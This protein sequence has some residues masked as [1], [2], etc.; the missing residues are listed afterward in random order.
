[1]KKIMLM[2]ILAIATLTVLTKNSNA[3]W[4]QN[5]IGGAIAH[6]DCETSGNTCA[7]LGGAPLHCDT[8]G[9]IYWSCNDSYTERDCNTYDYWD[10][11]DCVTW[12][13]HVCQGVTK[14]ICDGSVYV[15]TTTQQNNNC[16]FNVS[17]CD[18]TT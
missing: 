15:E 8:V 5:A 6:C 9:Q 2:L 7:S 17:A 1:M 10:W 18:P 13:P 11:A 14:W 3:N 16:G 4:T 12:D